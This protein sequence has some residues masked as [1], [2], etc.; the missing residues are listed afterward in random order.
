MKRRL[1]FVSVAER[2]TNF[3]F[4]SDTFF[5]RTV[6]DSLKCFV[7]VLDADHY[8]RRVNTIED[9]LAANQDVR[10]DSVFLHIHNHKP[11]TDTQRQVANANSPAGYKP[12]IPM[13]K[14]NFVDASATVDPRTQV[15]RGSQ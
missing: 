3:F 8:C 11:I 1:A 2:V 12:L 13:G 10:F 5:F 4:S 14:N 9:Y 7:H 15:S 6:G